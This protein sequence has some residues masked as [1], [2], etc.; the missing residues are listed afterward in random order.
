MFGT[1]FPERLPDVLDE[2]LRTHVVVHGNNGNVLWSLAAEAAGVRLARHDDLGAECGHHA[3]GLLHASGRG[4]SEMQFRENGLATFAA[5]G[6]LIN[7]QHERS[8]TGLVVGPA[9]ATR[10]AA[11]IRTSAVIGC[12]WHTGE[13]YY[14]A[15]AR[16]SIPQ[17][18]T[19]HATDGIPAA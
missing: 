6:V 2:R 13:R 4:N 17:K 1:L 9:P 16:G 3:K 18:R 7:K 14:D 10:T 5:G 8:V 15:H 12:T 19:R 11:A